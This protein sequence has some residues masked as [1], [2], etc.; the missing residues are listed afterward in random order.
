MPVSENADQ[1]AEAETQVYAAT[2]TTQSLKRLANA[3]V[4]QLSNDS[5]TGIAA[6]LLNEG[7]WMNFEVI[8]L[9][10]KVLKDALDFR[11]AAAVS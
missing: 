11:A 3:G 10:V 7:T 9:L 6:L 1:V 2:N 5:I 4:P 8:A